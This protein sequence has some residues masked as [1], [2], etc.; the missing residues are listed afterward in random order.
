MK[1]FLAISLCFA[2]I[3]T[4]VGWIVDSQNERERVICLAHA[5][6]LAEV[7]SKARQV[8][9]KCRAAEDPLPIEF[10]RMLINDIDGASIKIYSKYPFPSNKDG[11]LRTEEQKNAWKAIAEDGQKE[12]VNSSRGVL[13][14]AIPDI[15]NASCVKCHN[16]HPKTPKNDWKVGDVRGIIDVRI[17]Y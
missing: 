15:M 3:T 16:S 1:V 2:A 9:S 12:Y 14:Y 6:G 17:S 5:R 11:G 10:A 7:V 4:S 13:Q 8:Y